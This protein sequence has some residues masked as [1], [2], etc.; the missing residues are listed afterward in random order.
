MIHEDFNGAMPRFYAKFVRTLPNRDNLMQQFVA[1]TS[2][3]PDGAIIV[4][5]GMGSGSLAELLLQTFPTIDQYVGIEPAGAMVAALPSSLVLDDRFTTINQGFEDWEGSTNSAD[6]IISRYVLHDFPDQ[7]KDWY[8]KITDALKPGGIFLNL[9]V[10]IADK[11]EETQANLEEV[12]RLAE[13]VT[14]EDKDER[15]A[16]EQFI[17]HLREEINRYRPLGEHIA[18]LTSVGLKP[19]VIARS[20]NNYLLKAT[21]TT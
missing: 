1:A 19:V 18:L 11:P 12:I 21:R 9:D 2:N 15:A 7:L 16:K 13:S 14:A 6:A 4:E 5:V 3:I 20:G 8:Q 10:T 17:R